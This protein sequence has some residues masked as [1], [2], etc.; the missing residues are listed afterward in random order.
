MTKI[1]GTVF[2][3]VLVIIG[4]GATG[5]KDGTALENASQ[6]GDADTPGGTGD[7]GGT[8]GNGAPKPPSE[9]PLMPMPGTMPTPPPGV[10]DG[11]MP[12]DRLF[13]AAEEQF[14]VFAQALAGEGLPGFIHGIVGDRQIYVFTFRNPNTFFDFADFV[15]VPVTDQVAAKLAGVKRHDFVAIKGSFINHDAP[16]AHIF[17]TDVEEVVPYEAEGVTPPAAERPQGVPDALRAR[18][19]VVAK[20]HALDPNG[21]VLVVEVNDQVVPVF[22]QEPRYTEGLY[23]MDVVRLFYA[24]AQNP[25]RPTHLWL[26]PGR[27]RPI[28]VINAIVDQHQQPLVLEGTLVKFPKSPQI[29]LDVYAVQVELP[30]QGE[31]DNG[32]DLDAPSCVLTPLSISTST[33][34]RYLQP[35]GK[36]WRRFGMP[37]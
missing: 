32:Q 19:E 29:S 9:T 5:C 27:E 37:T 33:T 17:V 4:L 2:A 25:G 23:R 14:P 30:P 18:S 21:G 36:N 26:D 1:H 12:T 24:V 13:P 31:T 22:S 11:T 3:A 16:Q 6:N 20:V 34:R 15:L 28:E 7:A 10:M 8:P 35:S